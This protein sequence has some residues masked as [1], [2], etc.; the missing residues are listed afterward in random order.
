MLACGCVCVS[1]ST[2]HSRQPRA[3]RNCRLIVPAG[4][5]R[6]SN[7]APMQSQHGFITESCEDRWGATIRGLFGA[8]WP[9][10]LDPVRH[11]QDRRR[12]LLNGLEPLRLGA[13]MQEDDDVAVFGSL[14][15]PP[16]D[17]VAIERRVQKAKPGARPFARQTIRRPVD[18]GAGP[19]PHNRR[20]RIELERAES[21]DEI[22]RRDMVL[23]Q[24][25]RSLVTAEGHGAPPV[26]AWAMALASSSVSAKPSC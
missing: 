16:A 22:L 21:V 9:T 7:A 19:R 12:V 15:D 23:T 5:E 10:E 13:R 11:E 4:D 8:V 17:D 25:N 26:W 14:G 18:F 3:H 2:S 20:C 1:M 6:P 24:P